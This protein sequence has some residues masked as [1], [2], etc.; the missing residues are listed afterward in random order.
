VSVGADGSIFVTDH[1]SNTIRRVTLDGT[2]T[3]AAGGSLKTKLRD[4]IGPVAR[5]K[6]PRGVVYV[7]AFGD[8]L[9]IDQGHSRLR[10]IEP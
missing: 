9:V 6:N 10:R 3:T 5:F 1:G 7:P 8:F 4:G 2:T